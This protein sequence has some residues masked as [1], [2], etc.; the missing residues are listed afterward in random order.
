MPTYVYKCDNCGEF[1]VWQS[2]ND[3]TYKICPKCNGNK[4]KRL[5]TNTAGIIMKAKEQ[6][7]STDNIPLQCE[8][9]G[10]IN[11]CDIKNVR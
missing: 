11:E 10:K 7:S 9:C 3:D 4:V 8:G 6:K 5:V 1:E 2:I